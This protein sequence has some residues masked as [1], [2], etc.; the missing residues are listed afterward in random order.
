MHDTFLRVSLSL[1]LLDPKR[2]NFIYRPTTLC[3]NMAVDLSDLTPLQWALLVV[4]LL[5]AMAGIYYLY[6]LCCGYRC[7]PLETAACEGGEPHFLVYVTGPE[8]AALAKI[9]KHTGPPPLCHGID[10]YPKRKRIDA[11]D[12]QTRRGLRYYFDNDENGTGAEEWSDLLD[13][14]ARPFEVE[15]VQRM[16]QRARGWGW[17]EE[18]LRAVVA[19]ERNARFMNTKANRAAAKA[20]AAA[21]RAAAARA[22]PQ[23][24]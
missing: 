12:D 2:A 3:F 7:L 22:P 8:K 10:S 17:D 1:S 5:L 9:A 19:A 18:T 6:T 23:S 13:Y 20:V 15:Y 4:L 21:K 14:N 11:Y 24:S 16:R